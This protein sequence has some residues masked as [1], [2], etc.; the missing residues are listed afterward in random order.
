LPARGPVLPRLGAVLAGV[1]E[2]TFGRIGPVAG[3]IK[4]FLGPLRRGQGIGECILRRGQ[5]AAQAGQVPHRLPVSARPVNHAIEDARQ[6]QPGA[7][8]AAPPGIRAP[9]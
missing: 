7:M 4:S 8:Q 3:R 2:S 5:P 6:A 1:I 9:S